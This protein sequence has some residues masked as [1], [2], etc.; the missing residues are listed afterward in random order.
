MA[1]VDPRFSSYVPIPLGNH[2]N[3]T[4]VRKWHRIATVRRQQGISLRSASRQSRVEASELESQEIETSD[5]RLSDLYRWE[6]ILGVP[7]CELLLDSGTELS[8]PVMERARMVRI[9]KTVKSMAETAN[10]PGMKRLAE[11]LVEQLLEVMP[12]LREVS[13]WHSVG[14]RRSLNEYG[15]AAE[16]VFSAEIPE[17]DRWDT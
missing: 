16:R 15:R 9:M 2:G 6:S 4:H 11:T 5:L 12:E 1:T 14:Q 10:G 17:D 7:V 8:R 13:P 3:G